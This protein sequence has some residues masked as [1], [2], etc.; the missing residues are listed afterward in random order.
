MGMCLVCDF[1]LR[2]REF[3]L[4]DCLGNVF[5]FSLLRGFLGGTDLMVCVGG[6][7]DWEWVL[8]AWGRREDSHR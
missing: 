5:L 2:D 4:M 8:G 1:Y 6:V 7:G 3:Y